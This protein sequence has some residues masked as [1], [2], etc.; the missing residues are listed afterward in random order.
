MTPRWIVAHLIES[1]LDAILGILHHFA[2]VGIQHAG[3]FVAHLLRGEGG[4]AVCGAHK[5]VHP[6][7]SGARESVD[8][9]SS[10]AFRAIK[11]RY[12]C[13]LVRKCSGK[14]R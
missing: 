14:L 2:V 10:H 11:L 5:E 9:A 4:V 1:F 13:P 3:V 7:R 6:P 12:S 8:P